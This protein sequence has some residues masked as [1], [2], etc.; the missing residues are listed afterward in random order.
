[1]SSGVCDFV[2]VSTAALSKLAELDELE[3][4]VA[5]LTGIDYLAELAALAELRSGVS[6]ELRSEVSVELRS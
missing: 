2:E 1:M 5:W 3:E 6:M 4:P